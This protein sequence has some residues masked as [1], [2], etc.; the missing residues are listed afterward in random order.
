MEAHLIWTENIMKI[1]YKVGKVHRASQI[2]FSLIVCPESIW[3]SL[4]PTKHVIS[5]EDKET[6]HYIESYVSEQT[7]LTLL[8]VRYMKSMSERIKE[9]DHLKDLDIDEVNYLNLC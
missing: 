3:Q 5:Y 4:T 9:R 7:H 8:S 1:K 6:K 2:S